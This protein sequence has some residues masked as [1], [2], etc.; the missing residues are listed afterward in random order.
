MSK[1]SDAF[2][3]L[4]EFKKKYELS[5]DLEYNAKNTL[6]R[7]KILKSNPLYDYLQ[8]IPKQY[9]I[10]N[11]KLIDSKLL[12]HQYNYCGVENIKPE[13]FFNCSLIEYSDGYLLVY[14]TDLKHEKLKRWCVYINLHITKLNKK[15]KVVGDS[16]TL[17]LKTNPDSFLDKQIKDLPKGHHTEDPRWVVFKDKIYLFYTDGFK[18]L[19]AILNLDTLEIES[20]DYLETPFNCQFEKN[21]TPLI[22]DNDIY[23]IYGYSPLFTILKLNNN[24]PYKIDSVIGHKTLLD[25]V[26]KW[27]EIRGGTPWIDTHDNK[28]YVSMFHSSKQLTPIIEYSKV[29]VGG[30][31]LLDRN[32]YPVAISKIPVIRGEIQSFTIDRLNKNIFVVFPGGIVYDYNKEKYIISFGYNDYECRILEVEKDKIYDNLIWI[33]KH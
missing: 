15:Y 25:S 5:I 24:N 1:Y 8:E 9:D 4:N 16:K 2:N 7:N 30:F 27:G 12:V 13:L 26:W 18:Q 21:W 10:Q 32:F 20:S 19:L 33:N 14:R 3:T 31:I 11:T 28:Y 22:R 6:I 29:Y 23:L 17:I